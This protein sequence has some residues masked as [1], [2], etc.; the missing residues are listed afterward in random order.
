MGIWNILKRKTPAAYA[1]GGLKARCPHCEFDG[2]YKSRALLNTSGMTFLKLDWANKEATTLTCGRC[3]LVQWFAIPP[4][5]IPDK[6][7]D[8]E[9]WPDV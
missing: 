3:G 8:S 7:K 5:P 4:E 9:E 1:A 6:P 2:F